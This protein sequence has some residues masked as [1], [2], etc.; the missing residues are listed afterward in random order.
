VAGG[1]STY[2]AQAI[3]R[4]LGAIRFVG[5]DLV[6][7]APAYDHADTTALAAASIALDYLALRASNLPERKR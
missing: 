6:E 3:L 5:M 7:V 1:L 4:R 2:Q